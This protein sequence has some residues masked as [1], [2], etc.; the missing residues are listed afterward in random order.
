MSNLRGW[1]ISE[2]RVPES[3]AGKRGGR[4]REMSICISAN[5]PLET[6]FRIRK[7]SPQFH[8]YVVSPWFASKHVP[9]NIMFHK[10]HLIIISQ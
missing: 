1:D 2:G 6:R 5:I 9:P 3:Y 4:N 10:A 8:F 7:Y